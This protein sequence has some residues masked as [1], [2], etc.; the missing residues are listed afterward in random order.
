M[1]PFHQAISLINSKGRMNMKEIWKD[2]VGYEGLYKVNQWGEI[3][4][5][6]SHKKLK[7][8]ISSDG[9]K[10][11]NLHKNKKAFIMTAHK[12]VALAFVPN[13]NNLPV[14]NHKD[15]NKLNCFYENLEWCSVSYN[16]SYNNKA[17]KA[18]L[19]YSKT[20]YQYDKNGVLINTYHSTKEAVRNI[21]CNYDVLAA[22]C[23]K[24]KLHGKNVRTVKGYIFSYCEMSKE[25]VIEHFKVTKNN[26]GRFLKEKSK[27][28]QQ[29]TTDDFVVQ[30]YPSCCDAE[31]ETGF[32]RTQISRA[33]RGYEKGYVCHGYKW[34]YI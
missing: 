4:S 29:L 32:S 28:V 20:I 1:M 27:Q 9:Y 10:Q 15:E 12:A 21:G 30:S 16:N 31:R 11:Y 3:W 14:V 22:C 2:V 23:K 8:S 19:P 24:K 26:Q 13:P 6:Y 33:A 18:M 17:K 7:Y 5:E 25:E 34:R